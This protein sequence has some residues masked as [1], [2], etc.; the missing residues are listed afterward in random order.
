MVWSTESVVGIKTGDSGV[1]IA[2]EFDTFTDTRST[3][4]IV[5]LSHI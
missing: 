5:A 2:Y 4:H 1:V 3:E